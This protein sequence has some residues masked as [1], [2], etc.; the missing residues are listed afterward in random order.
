MTIIE[1]SYDWRYNPG[2]R[3][4]TDYIVLH[5]AAAN[6]GAQEIHDY[7]RNTNGWAGIGYHFYVRCD[8]KVY[9]T[10]TFAP[11]S[12]N[13]E[14]PFSVGINVANGGRSIPFIRPI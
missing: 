3:A 2:K 7:H 10:S 13:R 8:G 12:N 6:G 1:Q 11:Q 14:T 4:A 9:H 5:H